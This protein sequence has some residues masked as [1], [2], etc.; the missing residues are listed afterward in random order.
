MEVTKHDSVES[1]KR[2]LSLDCLRA[3]ALLL[4][5][6]RHVGP[7]PSDSPTLER[8]FFDF[9]HRGGWIGVDVFFVLSGFLVSGLLFADYKRY[10]HL[11]PIRFYIRRGFKIYPA[12][13]F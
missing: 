13:Y 7:P 3:L 1:G 8:Y 2:L 12:F 5:L 11:F 6:G 9:W 10:D 4:V